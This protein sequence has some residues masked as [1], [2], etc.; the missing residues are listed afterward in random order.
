MRT[1]GTDTLDFDAL[2]AF[3]G[4]ELTADQAALSFQQGQE[5]VDFALL[6]LANRLIEKQALATSIGPST[7]SG[8]T[9][10]YAK[11]TVKGR[12]KNKGAKPGHQG[13]RRAAPPRIDQHVVHSLEECPKCHGPVRP[14]RSSR[15]SIIEDIPADITPVVTEHV[16]QRYWCPVCRKTVEP[17]VNE[18]LPGSSIGLRVVVL[19]AWLHYLLGTTLA[20]IID[21]FNFHL[22]FKLTAGG[23]ISMWKRLREILF[24]WYLEIQEQ[25]LDSAVLHA[26]ETGWRV[27]GETHWLWCLTSKDVTYYMIDR[28][29]GSPELKRFFKKEFAG[30]LVTDFWGAYN[31]VVC[32]RK[33]KSLPHLLRDLKQTQ[34]Y[35]NPGGDW[36]KFSKLLKRL[37]RN[38]IRLSKHRRELSEEQFASKRDRLRKR[39]HDLLGKSCENKHAQR[40]VKRLR[41][42]V[43]KLFTFLDHIDVP[44]DNN[45]AEL[46][47][48]PAVMMRKNSFAN[49][50][51]EGAETKSV[52]M[53]VFRTLKQRG[54]NPISAVLDA[55][56][57]YLKT[58]DLP[59]LPAKIAEIG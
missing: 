15:T 17:V 26:Y 32:A 34:H 53:S 43:S 21:V 42:H 5:A 38:S 19:S 51:D 22:H 48:R 44:A 29:R 20:Q 52:L 57:T 40:L 50:N 35:H 16:I 58:G 30:V 54:Y 31:A 37:I 12:A 2:Q 4:P 56:R 39:L 7:P 27:N 46:E 3:L 23:L 24:A 33:Q 9:P 18:A 10:P 47:I 45:H 8:Q 25:A 6:T 55:I 28:R 14:C 36:P 41:S 59:S 11:P 13:H 49:G 1:S